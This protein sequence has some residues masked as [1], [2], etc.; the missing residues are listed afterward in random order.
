MSKEN[1]NLIKI[2]SRYTF[3]YP[4]EI[5]LPLIR[6][7]QTVGNL[8]NFI[9]K[10]IISDPIILKGETS[11]EEN[12]WFFIRYKQFIDIYMKIEEVIESE[13]FLRINYYLYKTSPKIIKFHLVFNLHFLN[14]NQSLLI[15]ETILPKININQNFIE[16]IQSETNFNCNILS[17]SISLDKRYTFYNSG[18]VFDVKYDFLKKLCVHYKLFRLLFPD[19]KSFEKINKDNEVFYY[20]EEIIK[21]DQNFKI[22]I[23]HKD[24]YNLPS[25]ILLK[26]SKSQ[27]LKSQSLINFTFS[28]YNDQENEINN[29]YK[30][31][32][33]LK[34]ITKNKTFFLIKSTCNN[35][36]KEEKFN[37]YSYFCEKILNNIKNICFVYHNTNHLERSL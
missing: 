11:F 8:M 4:F 16:L 24:K 12:T 3:N 9:Q 27:L 37:K 32:F 28:S 1:E 17:K 10:K 25:E 15:I 13:Y 36:I 30:M 6:N 18:T 35:P 14:E 2:M 34:R 31:I 23:K 33:F 21:E 19:I 26:I 5:M 7:I 22:K 20:D 29:N